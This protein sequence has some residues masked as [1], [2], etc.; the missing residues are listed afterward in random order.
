VIARE[1]ERLAVLRQTT[2]PAVVEEWC[3]DM[4]DW[5]DAAGSDRART[6]FQ[7][8]GMLRRVLTAYLCAA[9]AAAGGARVVL[10][11]SRARPRASRRYAHGDV[12]YDPALRRVATVLLSQVLPRALGAARG[13]RERESAREM[14]RK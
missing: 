7:V 5:K 9:A 10:T 3:P 12:A 11:H 6:P 14:A 8:L 1:V 13:A 2:C 4:R